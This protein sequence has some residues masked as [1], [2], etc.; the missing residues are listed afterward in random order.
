LGGIFQISG[1]GTVTVLEYTGGVDVVV[2]HNTSLG[3]TSTVYRGN[4]RK[5]SVKNPYTPAVVGVGYIG[6]GK[7]KRRTHE[8]TYQ[9]WINMLKRCYCSKHQENNPSYIGCTVDEE[10]HN[11]QEFAEWYHNHP[12]SKWEGYQI[13]KDILIP[14]NKIYSSQNCTLVPALLNNI[15]GSGKDEGGRGY[16]VR[17]RKSGRYEV[18]VRRF[19]KEHHV[20]TF[21]T[22]EEAH[23]AHLKARTDHW[24]EFMECLPED[25]VEEKVKEAMRLRIVKFRKLEEEKCT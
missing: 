4:L 16:G 8:R 11:F 15:V 7:F 25:A 17:K 12:N 23:L 2:T 24:E 9:V 18:R 20:G 21:D 22:Y 3:N 13:D 10:W 5:G 6:E 19:G 1:G 14:N